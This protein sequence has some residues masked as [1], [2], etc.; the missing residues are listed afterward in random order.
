MRAPDVVMVETATEVITGGAVTTPL[1][2]VMLTA[3]DVVLFPAESRATAVSVCR[4]SGT[5]AVFQATAN[6]GVLTSVPKLAPSMRNWTP[7]TPMLSEAYAEIVIAPETVAPGPGV[8]TVTTGGVV[9][10]FA[11]VSVTG[12]LDPTLPAASEAFAAS[13]CDPLAAVVVFQVSVYGRA[14]TAGPR[15][16]PSSVNC[17]LATPTL[18]EATAETVMLGPDTV[19]P[20]LGAVIATVG[21]NV[22]AAG[23][24]AARHFT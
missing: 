15:L 12:A 23:G 16:V 5:I 19:A 7:A 10:A 17:M 1:L 8:V 13:T 24:A 6:G 22:S 14:V 20:L 11:T 9:S 18:S 21:R 4:P 3:A 2:T